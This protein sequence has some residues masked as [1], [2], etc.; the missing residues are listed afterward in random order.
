MD[1]MVMDHL[2]DRGLTVPVDH[3][4]LL[5]AYWAKMRRLRADVDE[6]LLADHEIAVTYTPVQEQA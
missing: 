4:P 6:A 3:Q 2:H 5:E 1:P